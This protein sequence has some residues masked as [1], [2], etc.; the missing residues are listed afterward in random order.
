[1]LYLYITAPGKDKTDFTAFIEK[2]RGFLQN[3]SSSPEAAFQDTIAAVM[4]K[5]NYRS[6][7]MTEDKLGKIN[8]EKALGI[9]KERFS[10]PGNFTFTFVGNLTP[11]NFRPLVEQYIGGIPSVQRNETFK[12]LN[13]KT[14]EG[15]LSRTVKKGI[16]PKSS[17]T[18]KLTGPFM[19]DRRNRNN[20]NMLMNLVSIKLREQMRE[21][22]G[23]VYGVGA[24][25]VMTHYPDQTY[26]INFRWGCAPENVDMLIKTMWTEIDKIKENG[27]DEKD[28][29]K[30]K[31][32]AIRERETYLKDNRFWLS[33][34]SNSA[35]DGEKIDEILDYTNYVN[36]LTPEV[37]KRFA[38]QYLVKNNVATFILNPVK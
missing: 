26:E 2:Q 7:P 22:K 34:I 21:E 32:T 16:E 37:L 14:P 17:V 6:L 18:I 27:C 24:Y 30:I 33:A 13:L 35:M 4:G 25:P 19:Y 38:N 5:Y 10:N 28:L 11:D 31:E 1:M 29:Q 15:T 8:F 20:L 3:R 12:N 9:Y 23:G 36:A